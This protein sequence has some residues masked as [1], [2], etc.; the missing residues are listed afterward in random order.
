VLRRLS[1]IFRLKLITLKLMLAPF[2]LMISMPI[3]PTLLLSSKSALRKF[4]KL[5]L[6]VL[7]KLPL[8]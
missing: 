8:L 3:L 5:L 6:V 1:R 2:L 4:L 7:K